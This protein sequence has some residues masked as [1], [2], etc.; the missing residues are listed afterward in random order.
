MVK[1]FEFN[2]SSEF[3]A[4]TYIVG[5]INDGCL[6]ID[7]GSTDKRIYE[8]VTTH[9]SKV[10]GILLTHGHFDHIRG[11]PTFLKPFKYDIPVYIHDDDVELLT[12][13]ILNAS[14]STGHQI[15]VT[16]NVTTVT[17]NE[18]LNIGGHKVKVI[19]TPFHTRGSVCYLLENEN[20]IFTGDTLFKGSV[21][22]TDLAASKP[23]LMNDSLKKLIDLNEWL[24]IYPGHGDISNLKNEKENNPYLKGL[25]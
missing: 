13:P 2:N 15:K 12:N 14:S 17:D 10:L 4:N 20:A 8:Y 6:I 23:S 19:H 9:H 7:L 16:S 3:A 5:K 25:I 24:A 1:I 11:I 21:G 22:R 18:E